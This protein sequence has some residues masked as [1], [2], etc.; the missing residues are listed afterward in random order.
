MDYIFGRKKQI[1]SLIKNDAKGL[2]WMYFGLVFK[3]EFHQ[4]I[5]NEKFIEFYENLR[6]QVA[7]LPLKLN[8][9]DDDEGKLVIVSVDV[10]GG[11]TKPSIK[12]RSAKLSEPLIE[13]L[14]KHGSYPAS[15]PF[16]EGKVGGSVNYR[17]VPRPMI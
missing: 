9:T 3:G 15:M 14:I 6:P 2:V 11:G 5:I 8:F 1:I 12:E 7:R 10:D 17:D 16:I 4:I 13:Q